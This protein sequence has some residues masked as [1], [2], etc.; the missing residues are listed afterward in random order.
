MT[1]KREKA[2]NKFRDAIFNRIFKP[3][4]FLTQAE[5][6]K[7]LDISLGPLR[8][9]I[10]RLEWEELVFVIPQRGL[11]IALPNIKEIK[12]A[13]HFRIIL[14]KEAVR[15]FTKSPSQTVL[16]KLETA[17]HELAK[18]H[19]EISPEDTILNQ[20]L[21]LDYSLHE[22][23][24][25]ELKNNQLKQFYQVVFD[26]IRIAWIANSYT[27]EIVKPVM[28]EHIQVIDAI[29]KGDPELA[30]QVMEHHL[31]QSLRRIMGV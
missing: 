19:Q 30:A 3:G 26:K 27:R 2:Y 1:A 14:E 8:D 7:K 31:N 13:F 11:Q 17:T 22:M 9:A 20:A 18:K 29:K 15:H 23:L 16:E 6:S 28:E 5:L 4:Q 25:N 21:D 24:I 12:E 10:K